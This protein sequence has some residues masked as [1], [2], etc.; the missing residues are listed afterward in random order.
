MSRN[1][2]API[3]AQM[4]T[5]GHRRHASQFGP[6]RPDN[7]RWNSPQSIYQN[8]ETVYP[9]LQIWS[10]IVKKLS[11]DVGILVSPI[12]E[13]LSLGYILGDTSRRIPPN[14]SFT[15][16]LSL[17]SARAAVCERRS[18][19]ALIYPT[20]LLPITREARSSAIGDFERGW[21]C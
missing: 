10:L 11:A 20:F 21:C 5:L 17:S 4:H 6:S 14:A 1:H 15:L 8:V 2:L 9:N 12:G 13:I 16:S 3:N 18:V 7:N 19:G